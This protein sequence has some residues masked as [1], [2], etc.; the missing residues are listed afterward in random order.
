VLLIS[1]YV[2]RLTD[3][4]DARLTRDRHRIEAAHARAR[5]LSTLGRFPGEEAPSA[6]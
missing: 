2:D 3:Y 4:L 1:D 5:L 6:P